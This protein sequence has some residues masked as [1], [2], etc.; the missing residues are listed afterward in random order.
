M[1]PSKGR[2]RP[3][4]SPAEPRE[5]QGAAAGAAART[6]GVPV[7]LHKARLERP[8]LTCSEPCQVP[9]G[10]ALSLVPAGWGWGKL[11]L[12]FPVYHRASRHLAFGKPHRVLSSRSVF[13]CFVANPLLG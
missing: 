2:E 6:P 5:T 10:S 11:S 9:R 7:L 1:A 8:Q 13:G 12:C 4:R 3:A